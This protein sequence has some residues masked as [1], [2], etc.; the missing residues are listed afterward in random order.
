MADWNYNSVAACFIAAGKN[1]PEV[2]ALFTM[3]IKRETLSPTTTKLSVTADAPELD[4]IKQ[5]VLSRLSQD[6]KLPGFRAGKAPA[7]LVEKNID[8]NVLQSEFLNEAV[9]QLYEQAVRSEQVR[10]AAP[11]EINITKFVPFTTLEFTAEVETVGEITLGNYKN[12]KVTPPKAE[13]TAKEVDEVIDNLRQ[14]A[15]VKSAAQR[16]AKQGDEVTI[17]FTGVDPTTKE[18]IDG[19]DGQEYPLILGSGTFI[20]GFEEELIGLK[21]GEKKSFVIKFPADYGAAMLRDKEVNF[22]VTVLK[23]NELQKPKLDD[24]FAASA[25]PFKTVAELKKDI[26]NQLLKEK[27]SQAEQ[28]YDNDLLQKIADSSEVAIPK[29]IVEDEV[30]RLEEEE[31]RSITY[32]GQTWQ[33]HLAEEAVTE[34]QHRDRQRPL[35]ET[36]IK[37]G[38][39][40]GDIAEKEKITVTDEELK[41]RIEELKEQYTDDAMRAQLDQPENRRDIYSR[42]MI[43]KTVKH[44]RDINLAKPAKA[45][46]K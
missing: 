21:P 3:Q 13:V 29:T 15:A 8:Q 27:Q 20:P 33:E 22:T 39:L 43:D 9:N 4:Q 30:M 42:M 32:R 28:Q 19:A 26:K 17:D 40:L 18:H 5:I 24:Q 25:G 6:I 16:P 31:K 14:R 11:P 10:I 36:R 23:I 38:L 46:K 7:N 37:V 41:A 1:S 12:V 2:I 35:A 45:A 34:E 44:L